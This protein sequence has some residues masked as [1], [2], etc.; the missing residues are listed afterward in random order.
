MESHGPKIHTFFMHL[1]EWPLI[2]G[3]RATMFGGI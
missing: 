2:I 3:G 1:R